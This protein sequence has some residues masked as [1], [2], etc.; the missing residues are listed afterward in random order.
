MAC[1]KNEP[2]AHG[3][4]HAKSRGKKNECRAVMKPEM[5]KFGRH[6]RMASQGA[7]LGKASRP[8]KAQ[9]KRTPQRALN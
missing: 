7:G 3:E 2:K 1:N 4:H 5:G 6:S 9:N 8:M